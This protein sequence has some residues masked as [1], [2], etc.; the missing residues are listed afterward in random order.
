MFVSKEQL[1]DLAYDL[2][3]LYEDLQEIISAARY[4]AELDD[5]EQEDEYEVEKE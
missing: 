1:E 2:R 5:L 3:E 4:Q